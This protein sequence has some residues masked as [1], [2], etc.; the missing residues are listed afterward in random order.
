MEWHGNRRQLREI[1][2]HHGC[3]P[4][5]EPHH[6]F[7]INLVTATDLEVEVTP[8]AKWLRVAEHEDLEV[9]HGHQKG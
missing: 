5:S 8:S 7:I 4:D 2:E 9:D 1:T 6:L 3:R